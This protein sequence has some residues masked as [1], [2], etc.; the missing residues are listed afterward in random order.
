MLLLMQL[1]KVRVAATRIG[2]PT[3]H[4]RQ[5]N[6]IKIRIDPR[7]ESSRI[8]IERKTKWKTNQNEIKIKTNPRS[9]A[10]AGGAKQ[11][12]CEYGT[13]AVPGSPARS[14]SKSK[15]NQTSG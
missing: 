15:S 6:R 13:G 12:G 10:A 4:L 5:S 2:P 9:W 11:Q 1:G 3:I 7:V 14:K 8:K